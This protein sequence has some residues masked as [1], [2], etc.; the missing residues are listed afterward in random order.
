[1]LQI[2]HANRMDKVNH[3]LSLHLLLNSQ[4]EPWQRLVESLQSSHI[5]VEDFF[6]LE[7]FSP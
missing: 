5:P 1:M 2:C 7:A 6:L 3:N 4:L